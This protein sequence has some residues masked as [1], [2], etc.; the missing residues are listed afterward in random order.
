MNRIVRF[1]IPCLLAWC[2]PLMGE[3]ALI[4]EVEVRVRAVDAEYGGFLSGYAVL[5]EET[6]ARTRAVHPSE[7]FVRVPGIW[8]SRGSG[9]EHLTALRSGVL[10]GPGAC[11]S[12][13]YLED[14]IPI[15]PQGFCNVNNLFETTIE[16]AEAVEVLRGPSV[17]AFRGNPLYGAINSISAE[18]RSNAWVEIETGSDA[19]RGL[20][21]S[22]GGQA[23]NHRLG[24]SGTLVA[25][26][27]FRDQV[28]YREQKL[29]L[30]DQAHWDTWQ[31]MTTLALTNLDQ[32]TGGYVLGPNA[33]RDSTL[34]RGNPNPEAYRE[35]RS[36][37]LASHWQRPFA[38]GAE[39]TLA[40]YARWS[41][42]QFLQH[43]LPGQPTETNGQTSLGAIAFY[44]RVRGDFETAIEAQIEWADVWLE[45][46][47]DQATRGAAF[48]VET[49]PA[50]RHYDFDVTSLF[51]SVSARLGYA[52]SDAVEWQAGLRAERL[53]YDYS[54]RWLDGNT[55]DDGSRCGF[56]GCLYTRPAS[57]DD[58]FTNLG[59]ML[60][61]RMA[62]GTRGQFWLGAGSGFRPPQATELYRLQRG[63]LVAELDSERRNSLEAGIRLAGEA[64]DMSASTYVARS[65]DLIFRDAEGLNVSE[66][67][68][69]SVGIELETELRTAALGS[70][71]MVGSWAR[72]EY[73]FNRRIGGGEIIES[74]NSL[75]TAPAFMGSAR[76]TLRWR[77]SLVS[78]MEVVYLGEYWMN[79]HNTH[80]YGGHW[81]VNWRLDWRA[82][83]NLLLFARIGNLL[84]RDYAHRA[85]F[86][87]GNQRY[88]PGPGRQVFI[89]ARI[90]RE[91]S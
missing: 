91:G 29:K 16:L 76:W 26:D 31:S 51:T 64:F 85:D 24:L 9:Q 44:T 34:R 52:P 49:R 35:A 87:F 58:S 54:N 38:G 28:G 84:D 14:G 63:Q 79:A 59:A 10:T 7:L 23:G 21:G 57:R 81:L 13:L 4:E 41:H 89:G 18:A 55:R 3:E 43:F 72:H 86:A 40:P 37:R 68:T 5:D 88:F 22:I 2:A 17:A 70:F 45:Q 65:T 61:L 74:G 20:K 15:R 69:K 75:D 25:S 32:Q 82:R 11:G 30:V 6:L 73:D 39:L 42:M 67:R 90:H 60:G 62:L 78:E 33:Y 48:L 80:E 46:V 66:G 47:Q 56:G 8:I 71:E 53:G 50:G 12:L 27:G 83:R 19:R 36:A 1:A 77:E